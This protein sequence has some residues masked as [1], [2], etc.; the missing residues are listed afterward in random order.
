[1]RLNTLIATILIAASG[2]TV[3][4]ADWPCWRGPNRNGTA[5]DT[6]INRDW[7]ARPPQ[8]L[9]RIALHDGGFAGPS[10][11]DGKVFIVDH[12]GAEDVVRALDFATG[13]DIWQ[14][15]YP[16]LSKPDYGFTRSTP[17]YDDGR[18]YVVS[19]LGRVSCLDASQGAILWSVNMT[20]E[21]G[22]V[23]PQWGYAM[24]ALID[25]ERVVIVPG[26]VDAAVAVL[27]K[28]T[29]ETIWTGGGSD[30]PGYS[31]PVKATI[32]GVEQYV[33]FMGKALIG[34]AAED[35]RLLWRHPWETSSDVNAATP[36]VSG[37]HIFITSNYNR[38]CAVIAIEPSGPRV[39]WENTGIASHVSTPVYLNGLMFGS[40]NR[41]LV[42]L[43]PN[44]GE[45]VWRAPGLE[46]GGA[47][48][49]DG[50]IIVLAGATGEL[51]MF[52]AAPEMREL[53][54]F[55][56]LGGKESWTAPII[57]D[58]KLIVRNKQALVCLDIM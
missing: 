48:G 6:G 57:A 32:Q 51:M 38:G 12:E 44:T 21:F 11:A 50:T 23:R 7:N 34:V 2:C 30:F 13:Q 15:R 22:G 24:S 33:V 53:G 9:W 27:N 1:M 58:G 42:C 45:I 25:G 3:F 36:I 10:V 29:G 47:V 52:E 18:L 19:Y 28:Q 5:P 16:D 8:E 39:V 4:A 17:V 40:D 20:D 41:D 49:V 54:R 55:T 37:N 35:G 26:G 43:N 31:T 46:K 56:P 14:T